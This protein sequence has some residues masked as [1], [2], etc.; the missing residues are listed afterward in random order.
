MTG[1]SGSGRFWGGLALGTMLGAAATWLAMA[2]PWRSAAPPIAEA[3]DAAAADERRPS[4]RHRRGRGRDSTGGDSGRNGG[5]A[6]APVLSA[7]DRVMAWRGPSISLP[8]RDMDLGTEGGGRPLD[9][10]EINQTIERSSG[11]ILSCI[12]DALAGA[13][14]AGDVRLELLVGEDGAVSDVR[15]GAPRWLIE[16]GLVDCATRA[17]R[18]IRFPAT[19]APTVVTAPFHVDRD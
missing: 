15:V 18:R 4:R 8:A 9:A 11:P 16:H 12:R 10:S 5:D 17:A 19:G 13:E 1:S 2:R 3:A 7:A 14:L 6:P